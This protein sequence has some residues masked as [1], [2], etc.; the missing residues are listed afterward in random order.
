MIKK[1]IDYG[2]VLI[3][4]LRKGAGY[5]DAKTVAREH[6]LPESYMEK[7]AQEFKRVGWLESRRGAGG[8]YRLIKNDISTADIINFFERPFDVCPINRIL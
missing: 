3:E 4:C 8:G 6:G 7:V 1:K 2:L 5:L